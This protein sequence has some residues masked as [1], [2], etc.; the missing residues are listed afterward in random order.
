MREIKVL[1][2]MILSA[3]V[4]MGC[5]TTKVERVDVA[6]KIDLSGGWNDYD[7]KLVSE[8]MIKDCVENPWWLNFV[9][10]KG[11]NPVVI[12]G[13][14][15]NRSHEHIN[16]LVFVKFIERD[17]LNSGKII[18]VA[19]PVER[20][21]IRDEREDQQ[22]GLTDPATIAQMGRERGADYMLI[23]SIDSVK[24]EVKGKYAIL[25]QV[26]LELVNLTTNEKTWIGQKQIKK[27]VKNSKFSL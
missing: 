14:V 24:D 13:S 10:D 9:K 5:A 22:K 27:F 4:V 15:E 6:E 26:N 7:A 17:L 23:G 12:V 20:D 2:L 18:F 8:E 25:Y 11:R 3:L 21:E 19:S 1:S 16:S